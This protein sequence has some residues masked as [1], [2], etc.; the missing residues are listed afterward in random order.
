MI[1]ANPW[2]SAKPGRYTRTMSP[3]ARQYSILNPGDLAIVQERERALNGVLR[4]AGYATLDGVRVFEAGCGGGYNLRMF[5][6]WGCRPADLAGIDIDEARVQHLREGSPGFRVHSG[7]AAAIP[8]PDE[9]FDIC[10]AFTL[11]SSVPDETTSAAIAAEMTRVTRP[12]GLILVYDMRRR[13]PG[14]QAVHPVSDDDVR[15]WFPTC[16][17]RQIRLTLAPPVAR[18]VAARARP[19][20]GPLSLVPFAKTHTLHVMRRPA[21]SPI[22]LRE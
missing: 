7:S 17:P 18:F 15:R 16:R 10:I 8:E 12:G 19:L 1:R 20:Y 9:S 3:R 22:A 6:Q 4:R 13:S 2:R 5:Q 21:Q 11:F 14:N